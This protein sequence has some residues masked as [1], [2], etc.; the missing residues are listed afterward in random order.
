[1]TSTTIIGIDLAWGERRP[2]GICIIRASG[3]IARCETL[4]LSRGDTALGEV[5]GA[6]AR[7]RPAILAID[8]PVIVK[9]RKGARPVD[10]LTH[11][12]FHRQHAGC[13]PASLTLTPR[14]PR[15]ARRLSRLGFTIAP[16]LPDRS[17]RRII[18]VYPHI[19][20]LRLFGL[21]RI[22]KYKRGASADR[23]R[24]FSR[25]KRL[26]RECLDSHFPWIDPGP[27]KDALR[28]R[29]WSKDAED[30]IDASICALVGLHHWRHFGRRSEILG[31]A[32]TGFIVAPAPIESRPNGGIIIG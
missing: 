5:V 7:D 3:R 2:D 32:A 22:I 30:Q 27:A 20:C 12:L 23:A 9:N 13:H 28:C 8:G 26:L 16:D 1:M 6:T 17:A 11:T 24:E 31:D 18:E 25:L 19:A 21:D 4:A 14:P 10:R 29:G 15:V